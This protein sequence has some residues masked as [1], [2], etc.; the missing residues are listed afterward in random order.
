[1]FNDN[2]I[3]SP[4]INILCEALE[5][6]RAISNSLITDEK[7]TLVE[8]KEAVLSLSEIARKAMWQVGTPGTPETGGFL[9]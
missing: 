5:V 8:Y 9:A 4:N 1:M 7:A 2:S 6:I 3:L